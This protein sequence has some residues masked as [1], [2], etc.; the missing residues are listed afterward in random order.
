M[1]IELDAITGIHARIEEGIESGEFQ[2]TNAETVANMIVVLLEDWYLKPWKTQP[3]RGAE[4]SLTHQQDQEEKLEKY[5]QSL[6]QMV[7][8]LLAVP[9]P[10]AND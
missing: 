3:G 10:T 6:I 8:T 1:Q 9:S 2:A 5:Y 4:K 7:G